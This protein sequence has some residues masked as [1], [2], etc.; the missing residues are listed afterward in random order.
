MFFNQRLNFLGLDKL[1]ES[2]A[3]PSPGCVEKQEDIL[4]PASCGGFGLRKNFIS[5]GAAIAQ[6][7]LA[8]SKPKKVNR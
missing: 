1:I 5:A 8:K 4:V 3:P 6:K 2:A 7:T